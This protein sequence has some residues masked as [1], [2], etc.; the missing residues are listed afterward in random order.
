MLVNFITISAMTIGGNTMENRSYKVEFMLEFVGEEN[1]PIHG[2]RNVPANFNKLVDKKAFE[3]EL[4]RYFAGINEIPL[5][6]VAV[7]VLN[8]EQV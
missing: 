6:Q 4:Q 5:A 7:K 1:S 3:K 2:I 8:F